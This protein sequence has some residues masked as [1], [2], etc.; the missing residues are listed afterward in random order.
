MPSQTPRLIKDALFVASNGQYPP[1]SISHK[2]SGS[3]IDPIIVAA[4]AFA[5]STTFFVPVIHS[6][7]SNLLFTEGVRLMEGD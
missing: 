2:P 5:H 6:T 1:I 4:P 7:D 3:V